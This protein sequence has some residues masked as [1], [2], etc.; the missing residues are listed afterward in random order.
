MFDDLE[1]SKRS[2]VVP[3]EYC[4]PTYQTK[5]LDADGSLYR[6][7]ATDQIL[8]VEGSINEPEKLFYSK[9]MNQDIGCYSLGK[10]LTLKIRN[11]ILSEVVLDRNDGMYW[12]GIE[13]TWTPFLEENPC[14]LLT[15]N[16]LEEP[17][18]LSNQ[19]VTKE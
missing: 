19:E 11:G 6:I 8:K 9:N 12:D 3:D 14:Q 4:I 7:D 13:P 5:D 15:E 16:D 18:S 17:L 2:K 1:I 10:K